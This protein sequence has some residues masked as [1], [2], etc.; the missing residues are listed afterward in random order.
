MEKVLWLIKSVE[1]GLWSFM[2]EIS[3][4][5][6]LRG[7]ADYWKLTGM[8]PR[9]WEQ[10]TLL[11]TATRE[12]VAML[13]MLRARTENRSHQPDHI[14][15]CDSWAPRKSSRKNLLYLISAC[16]S[17]L[18]H[19]KNVPFL[20]HQARKNGYCT[21]VWNRRD[22]RASEMSH[23]QPH[24]SQSSSKEDD[25]YMVALESSSLLWAP[26]RKPND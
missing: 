19:N 4:W 23:H 10:S 9:H 11:H 13:K 17:L 16:D 6:M 21:K 20:K 15:C 7:S 14:H 24:Q 3:H 2:L 18:K 8:K 12:T 22:H 26:S 5:M 1:S 25:V